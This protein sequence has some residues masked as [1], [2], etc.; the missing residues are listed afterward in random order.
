M[1]SMESWYHGRIDIALQA[2]GSFN[3]LHVA[4]TFFEVILAARRAQPAAA[5]I[6]TVALI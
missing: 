5:E 6:F 3:V 4:R 2:T 1:D